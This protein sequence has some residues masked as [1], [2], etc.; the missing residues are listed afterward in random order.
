MV[1]VKLDVNIESSNTN[2]YSCDMIMV[3]LSIDKNRYFDYNIKIDI[4][5]WIITAKKILVK[6]LTN[7]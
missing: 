1:I 6:D 5:F 3:I 4:A 2:S 7:A